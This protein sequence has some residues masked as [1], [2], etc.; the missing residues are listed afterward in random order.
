MIYKNV[1]KYHNKSYNCKKIAFANEK[2]KNLSHLAKNFSYRINVL[3]LHD[4]VRLC[5]FWK[6]TKKSSS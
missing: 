3:N 1:I 5:K 2:M 6:N 4:F